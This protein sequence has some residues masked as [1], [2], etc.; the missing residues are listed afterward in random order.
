MNDY[1]RRTADWMTTTVARARAIVDPPL[2][3]DARPIEVRA[4]LLD[5]IAAMAE[6]SGS[7]R[8]VFPYAEVLATIVAENDGRQAALDTALADIEADV[9][10]R[11]DEL[12]C[13]RR[14]PVAVRVEYIAAPP[15]DWSPAQRYSLSVRPAGDR[16]PDVAMSG[17]VQLEVIRGVAAAASYTLA[18]THICIGRTAAPIDDRGRLRQ[19]HVVFVDGDDLSATVG[20]AHASIR[21][22]ADR[23][24]YRLFD[25]GSS[26]GTRIVRRGAVMN[27]APRD[28]VGIA[29]A[30]GDEILL[31]SA[32]LRVTLS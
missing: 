13:E 26:N 10:R 28:P 15:E 4:H 5:D 9:R 30:S 8:R 32:A 25:D 16:P 19:N 24:E 31:G 29:L 7:G 21:Y 20:R 1:L 11:L 17:E 23:R 18:G 22:D 12:R 2:D 14:V 27:V 6:P 3:A